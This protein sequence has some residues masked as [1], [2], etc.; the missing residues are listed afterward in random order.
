MLFNSLH[1]V[2]TPGC[3]DALQRNQEMPITF[4]E[5]HFDGNWGD[6]DAEDK[7]ANE[8]ALKYGSR[9]LSAYHLKDKTKIW[10]ITDAVD[11]RGIRNATTLLLPE[12]Y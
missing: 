9:I 2:A 7:K 11:G 5:K 1:L 3:L 12:E 8:D 4:L 6:L 10:I